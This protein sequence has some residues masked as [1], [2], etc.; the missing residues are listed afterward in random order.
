MTGELSGRVAIVTGANHGIGAA[1]AQLLAGCWS[2][3]SPAGSSPV[4]S[5]GTDRRY[6]FGWTAR[7]SGEACADRIPRR[8]VGS[9]PVSTGSVR[10]AVV[11]TGTE[12]GDVPQLERPAAKGLRTGELERK[13][14]HIFACR[15]IGEQSVPGADHDGQ[16]VQIEFIEQAAAE[17]ASHQARAARY[18]DGATRAVLRAAISSYTSVASTVVPGQSVSVTERE[19]T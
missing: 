18:E 19:A 5:P 13:S 11:H 1:M 2:P 16:H 15:S 17:Q 12:I 14:V 7:L 8:R 9:G 6:D 3:R 4:R 10:S